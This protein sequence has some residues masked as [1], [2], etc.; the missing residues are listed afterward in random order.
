MTTPSVKSTLPAAFLLS[1]TGWFGLAFVI[2]N[3]EPTLWPR[4]WFFF[5]IVL[6]ATGVFLPVTS[7]LNLRFRTDPQAG[8]NVVVREA[9]LAGIFTATIAWLQLGRAL[10]FG[11]GLL[12]AAGLIA[13]ELLLRMRERARWQP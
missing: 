13:I 10:T 8:R 5:F 2:I 11:V 12:L 7:F 3:K 9:S 1:V 6:A 4:W